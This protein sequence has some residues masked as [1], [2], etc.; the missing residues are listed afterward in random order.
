MFNSLFHPINCK[1][2]SSVASSEGGLTSLSLNPLSPG[3]T[4]KRTTPP[5]LQHA[6]SLFEPVTFVPR[7][8]H[9]TTSSILPPPPLPSSPNLTISIEYPQPLQLT[10][11]ISAKTC[12]HSAT[13]AIHFDSIIAVQF[14]SRYCDREATP[15]HT[16]ARTRAAL[17]V[18]IACQ[19]RKAQTN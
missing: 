11:D 4:T 12:Q 5:R 16:T 15:L 13:S 10:V 3:S 6:P 7:P 18:L 8:Q 14:A 19:I 1:S 9:P 2:R 17:S